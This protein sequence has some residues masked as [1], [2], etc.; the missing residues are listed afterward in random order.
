MAWNWIRRWIGSDRLRKWSKRTRQAQR[1]KPASLAS[2][3]GLET[4]LMLTTLGDDQLFIYLL[5]KI[6]HDPVQYGQDIG[7]DLSDVEARQPLAVNENLMSSAQFKADEMAA[8]NYFDHRSHTSNLWPNQLAVNNGYDLPDNF[9]LNTNNIESIAAGTTLT[10]PADVIEQL[11]RDVG[12]PTLDHRNHLLGIDDFNALAREIGAGHGFDVDSTFTNYWAAHITYSDPGDTFLTGV[13]YN[14]TNGDHQFSLDEG[15]SGV[16]VT[17]S[18]FGPVATSNAAGGWSFRVPGPGTYTVVVAGGQF[19]GSATNVVTVTNQ[20][21]E[22]DFTSG[23]TTG[24]VDFNTT[25]NTP[26][27]PPVNTVPAGPLDIQEDV[28]FPITGIS[29]A[30]PDA[31]HADVSVTLSVAHG[32]LKIPTSVVGGVTASQV[33]GNNS[34][35]VVLTA[36]IAKINAT[37]AAAQGLVYTGRADYNGSDVLSIVTNDLGHSGTGGALTDTDTVDLQVDP[38]NDAPVNRVPNGSLA[39]I[40]ETSLDV[41]GLRVTDVDIGSADALV[42]LSVLHGTLT[43]RTDVVGGLTPADIT[44]NGTNSVTITA[45][46][47]ELQA[48]LDAAGGVTYTSDVA[49]IGP[50]TLTLNSNDQGNTGTGGALSDQDTVSI[51]VQPVPVPPVVTLPAEPLS[52]PIEKEVTIG[53][54]A[55]VTDSDS[56]NFSGGKLVIQITAGAQAT[57][58]L[59]LAK[60]FGEIK[61]KKDKLFL[62]KTQIGDISGGENGSPLQVRFTSSV[63][64]ST[65]QTV[66]QNVVLRASKRKLLAGVRTIQVVA[67]DPT[68]ASS[69]AQTRDVN[70]TA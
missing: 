54:G 49:Y 47:T 48:T 4:R 37:L 9:Q 31:V 40:T 18:G 20:N 12:V 13:I 67:T 55:T 52:T 32:K 1:R 29:V 36:P 50:D 61:L 33:S 57:D 59:T 15:L 38:I 53:T 5:N 6:R 2:V 16:S 28:A 68:H 44:G 8:N 17:L 25:P 60:K 58:A 10:D 62:G 3:E 41:T 27:Q 14:D 30:D 39:V 45:A 66:L 34:D 64:V 42:G 11:I 35:E 63:T 46:L 24:V 7:L 21:R 26:N 51:D 65:V 69:T 23:Q 19:Q 56:P 43:L 22:I 70:V